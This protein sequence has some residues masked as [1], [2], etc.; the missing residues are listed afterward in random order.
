[1]VFPS[2]CAVIADIPTC[3]SAFPAFVRKDP[4]RACRYARHRGSGHDD[5]VSVKKMSTKAP[6]RLP[7]Q[8][9]RNAAL[10]KAASL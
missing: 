6:I 10:P 4:W 3:G 7:G 1:M 2:V 5:G 8:W 9:S